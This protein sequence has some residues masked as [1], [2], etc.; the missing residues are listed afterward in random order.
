[1]KL[2]LE[3][4]WTA[5]ALMGGLALMAPTVAVSAPK[6]GGL[7]ASRT[8]SVYFAQW[9]AEIGP[10]ARAALTADQQSFK[11]CDIERVRIVGLAGVKGST[12]KNQQLSQKRGDAVA[13]FLTA[14]GWRRD[15]MEIVALGDKGATR[16]D[17]ERPIRRRVRVTVEAR[18]AG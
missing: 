8:F 15:R 17:A 4:P 2:S 10:D 18:P 5:I 1:M 6:P 3:K 7:C 12:D 14:A 16:G 11:D 13:S 9:R